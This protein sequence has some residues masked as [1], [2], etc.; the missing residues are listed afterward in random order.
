MTM[1]GRRDTRIAL[2]GDQA[3]ESATQVFNLSAPLRPAAAVT[4]RSID[5]IRAAI[6]YADAE[7]LPIRVHTTG[8]ASANIRPVRDAVLIRTRMHGDVEIDP[9]RRTARVPAGTTWGAVAEAAA[10]H[11]L[12]A[13]HGSS[14][15]VGVVGY[16]LR[17]GIS[18]YG[19]HVGI[20]ANSLRAVELVTADGELRRV[21]AASDPELF[22][23]LRGGGGGFG[24]VTSVEVGL[25][26]ATGVIT[27]A[28]YWPSAHAPALLSAWRRWSRDAPREATTTF[29]VMNLPDLPEIPSALRG[30]PVVCVDGVVLGATGDAADALRHADGLLAPLRAVA[31]PVLDTWRPAAPPAALQTHM[32]PTE[33]FPIF[34]DHMLLDELGDEGSETFLRLA[35]DP[36][37]TELTNLELRQ[38]GGALAVPDP[39]GGVF[40]HVKADYAY[41]GGGVPFGSVTP[42]A[43]RGRCDV[44]RAALAPWNTGRT[45]PTFVERF[46][47]AQGHLTAEQIDAVDRVR[48]R[49][50]PRGRFREDISAEATALL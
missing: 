29:R 10:V 22:W 1:T 30:G 48:L 36:S 37:R 38:L 33:P 14:P 17:G 3:F 42:E 44:I 21:D 41:M 20:A 11:G 2:P 13:P 49:I 18:F 8:H 45:A 39:A 19:R 32:E 35:A 40:D 28:A 43:I 50:D 23:A 4:A 7:R 25:F 6:G 34:G 15:L 5:D 31:G 16:L 24:V 47:Q 46:E 12:A 27:G 26:P 9:Q